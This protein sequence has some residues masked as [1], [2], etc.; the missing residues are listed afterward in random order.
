MKERLSVTTN[1]RRKYIVTISIMKLPIK[2]VELLQQNET[3]ILAAK[4]FISQKL[5]VLDCTDIVTLNSEEFAVF[6][7]IIP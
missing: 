5:A 6:L 4:T 3:A 7:S 1:E 2:L